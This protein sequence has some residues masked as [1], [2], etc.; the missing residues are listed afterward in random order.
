VSSPNRPTSRRA[1]RGSRRDAQPSSA[2]AEQAAQPARGLRGVIS[3]NPRAWLAGAIAVGF[4][5]LGSGAV[6]AGAVVGDS[7]AAPIDGVGTVADGRPTPQQ[8]PEATRLRTCSVSSITK[9]AALGTLRA[10]VTNSSSG[11]L[12]FARGATK[13]TTQGTQQQLFTAAAALNILGKDFR[14]STRVYDGSV[15]G[16][17]VLVGTGDP[18]ITALHSG[19]SVYK[20]AARLDDLA[21]QVNAAYNDAHPGVPITTIVLDTSLW[22]A[23]D[24][25][26]T[27]WSSGAISG[28][29]LSKITA[30][31]VDGDRANPM[32]ASSP[33]STN[34]VG[35]AGDLFAAALGATVTF[36]DGQAVMSNTLL[37]E[38]KS[39]KLSVLVNQMLTSGDKTL[40]EFIA[41]RVSVDAGFGGSTSSVGEG[42]S[43]ALG[44]YDLDPA[45]NQFEDGSGLSTSN[46]L[47][48]QFV[49]DAMSRIR[50][51]DKDLNIIYNSLSEAGKKGSLASRFQGNAAAGH[52]FARPGSGS[53]TQSL[54]GT[55]DAKDGTSLSFAIYATGKGVG[56]AANPVIDKLVAA[57]YKCGDNL[58][59]N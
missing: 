46:K 42:I 54:V 15:D 21:N 11:E 24:N 33:R 50:D 20:G 18:T 41:R 49:A 31:Q 25:W 40:A 34:P 23:G 32:V 13:T 58:S 8:L 5:V 59:N 48:P 38:V 16:T 28:G 10:A 47:Q 4:V 51:G 39:Q 53:G 2:S 9:D 29:T 3:R 26:N 1:N 57:M 30:L 37:G 12:L 36:T 27:T 22:P 52:V 17:I 35:R 6:V 55:I 44:L 56:A 43:S 19:E 45:G 7:S 14:F